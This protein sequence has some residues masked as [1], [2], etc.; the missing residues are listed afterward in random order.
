[1][2]EKEAIKLIKSIMEKYDMQLLLMDIAFYSAKDNRST[3]ESD[4]ETLDYIHA[5]CS[6]YSPEEVL[7]RYKRDQK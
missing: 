3:F 6:E 1:M 5:L 2:N 4:R 7:K